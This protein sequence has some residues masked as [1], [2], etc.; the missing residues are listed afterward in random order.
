[1]SKSTTLPAKRTAIQ[2]QNGETSAVAE[3]VPVPSE[4]PRPPAPA[5][6]PSSK[7]V[8]QVTVWDP[9]DETGLTRDPHREVTSEMVDQ[10]MSRV[11]GALQSL[12]F[13]RILASTGTIRL[14]DIPP[15]Y[16]QEILGAIDRVT[17]DRRALEAWMRVTRKLLRGAAPEVALRL[18]TIVTGFTA[19]QLWFEQELKALKAG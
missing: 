1:M 7:D 10:M 19:I 12:A 18:A 15:E 16:S 14:N 17:R 3:S 6:P 11:Y 4:P 2:P 13:R 9:K 8:P 5:P